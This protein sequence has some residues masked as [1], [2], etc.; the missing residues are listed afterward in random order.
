MKFK[1]LLLLFSFF[2]TA[3]LTGC[4]NNEP[5]KK[6]IWFDKPA[7]YFEEAFPLGNGF[8]GM[9]V[10]GGAPT[11]D[12]ILNESS[13]WTGGPVDP[14]MNPDAWKNL[15]IVRKALFSEY[16]KLAET[17]VKKMQGK[18]SES[19]AHLEI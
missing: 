3:I 11:E 4:N 12:L 10:K 18:F 19:Y 15:E 14:N 7:K 13:L 9:M 5:P 17:L 8:I 16:Y 2:L 6:T 1:N